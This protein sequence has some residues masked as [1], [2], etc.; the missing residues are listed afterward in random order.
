MKIAI[1]GYGKMG[2]TIERLAEA[3][4]HEIVLRISSENT[5]EMTSE[6]LQKADV[7][8]EFSRPE[9][10]LRNIRCCLEVGLPVV[11]G[12]TG[13]LAD[14]ETVKAECLQKGGA[15]L[16][17]SNFS[18]GVNLFF[19]LNEYLASM[20]NGQPQYEVELEEIHHTQK[21][22]APSGTGISLA[23]G[24]L[25]HL[26]RKGRWRNERSEQPEDLALLSKR[27]DKV[28]GTHQIRYSSR[29][30]TIEIKHTAHSREGFASGAIRAAEWLIGKQGCFGMKDVLGF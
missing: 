19:A 11:S 10:A 13:W 16:Y 23:E 15:F 20:M 30:D 17:A 3:A 24:V 21:L 9:E 29:E 12:T 28:P 4:G 2:K 14:Y 6:S 27:I 18:I 8:I 25:R 26:E 22:D 5:A 7:A 1:I